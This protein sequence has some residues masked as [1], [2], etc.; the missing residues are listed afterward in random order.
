[1]VQLVL[2]VER[3]VAREVLL[4][5]F[6]VTLKQG[7]VPL[8]WLRHQVGLEHLVAGIHP[9]DDFL[10]E[11]DDVPVYSPERPHLLVQ[12]FDAW[13]LPSVLQDEAF[14][15][16]GCLLGDEIPVAFAL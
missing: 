5:L 4:D 1:M 8:A 2:M 16:T 15:I 9:A 3:G 12:T 13:N 11:L 7:L 6:I 10:L 14:G